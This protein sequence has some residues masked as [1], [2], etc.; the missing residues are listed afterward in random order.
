MFLFE[1][2]ILYQDSDT[3]NYSFSNILHYLVTSRFLPSNIYLRTPLSAV[4][5]HDTKSHTLV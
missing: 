1:L 5:T 4:K 2:L 3:L